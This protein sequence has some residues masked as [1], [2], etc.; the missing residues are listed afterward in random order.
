[1]VHTTPI[2]RQNNQYHFGSASHLMCFFGCSKEENFHG[3]DCH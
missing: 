1:M 2:I 3:D